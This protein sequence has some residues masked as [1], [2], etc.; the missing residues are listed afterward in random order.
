ML[1]GL[2]RLCCMCYGLQVVL[3]LFYSP[4]PCMHQRQQLVKERQQFQLEQLK[5]VELRQRQMAAQ[6]L[7]AEGKLVI[8]T[9]IVN[10]TAP[11]SAV[12]QLQPPQAKTPQPMPA[13][14]TPPPQTT[15]QQQVIVAQQQPQP[16][17]PQPPAPPPSVPSPAPQQQQ[18][19]QQQPP[20]SQT[21]SNTDNQQ[22]PNQV[23]QSEGKY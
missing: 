23:P 5:T 20:Q 17:T 13:A 22:Q 15:Q 11:A 2:S 14:P 1:V 19:Q 10:Q 6:N 9:V 7:L 4:L 21:P 16:V 12:V 18:Q 3:D 8:P